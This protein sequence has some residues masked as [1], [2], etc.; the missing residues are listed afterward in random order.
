M[1]EAVRIIG[2]K[3][4]NLDNDYLQ[5]QVKNNG[6]LQTVDEGWV[7]SDLDDNTTG[8][9]T[10]IFYYGFVDK[11]ASWYI[12]RRD[13][14]LGQ[15]RF[16]SGLSGYILAWTNRASQSYDYYYNTFPI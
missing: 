3:K 16:A 12:M 10:D 11:T 7:C 2:H 14:A 5:A 4:N 1:A 9:A 13:K 15:F 6:S 8:N